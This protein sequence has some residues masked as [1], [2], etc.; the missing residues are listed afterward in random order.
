MALSEQQ[1]FPRQK[2]LYYL[3]GLT[4]AGFLLRINHTWSES[5]TAD[6]ASALLRLQFGTFGEMI[7]KGV[8]PD[9]HPAFTQTLLWFWIKLF[10]NSEFSI[11]LP[12][13]LMGT[14][15][16]WLSGCA[17]RRWFGVGTALAVAA[18]VAFLQL[19]VMYSQLA[20][21]YAAGLFFTML[22]ACAASRFS[23]Q[24]KIKWYH[25]AV[26]AV[27]A[28]GAAYS[29]YFSLLTTLLL[30]IGGVFLAS[31]IN[32]VSY[33]IACVLALLLFLP[34]V[35]ITNSQLE[36][37]GIGGPGG[38][39]APPTPDFF[40][41]HVLVIFDSSRGLTYL[42][43]GIAFICI[44]INNHRPTKQQII[45]LLIWLLPLLTGY[46]YSVYKN[47]VLQHSVLL[48]SFP[49]F[50][51]FLF[52]WFPNEGDVR[53]PWV[54]ANVLIIVFASYITW[55]KP[56]RLTDHFGRLKEL[57]T[58][59]AETQEQNQNVEAMYN[60][61]AP[62]FI[63]YYLQRHPQLAAQQVS[64]VTHSDE[65]DEMRQLRDRV[66][67]SSADY[68]VYGWSTR[69]S[70][71]AA[72]DIIAL[73]FPCLIEKHEWFNSAVYVFAR[74]NQTGE[75]CPFHS[76][77]LSY[78]FMNIRAG[79]TIRTMWSPAC[80][81]SGDAFTLDSSCQYGPLL[82]ARVG[83]VLSNPDNEIILHAS[84][85]PELAGTQAVLVVEYMRDG[86]LLLWTGMDT[87]TQLDS[88][89]TGWQTVYFGQRPP[90]RLLRSDSIRAYVYTPELKRIS[91]RNLAFMTRLGHRGIHG[92]RPD[93]E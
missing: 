2:F 57:V 68:F 25:I 35:G 67:H 84:L 92:P 65:H 51:M 86:Q 75:Q 36:I 47:P 64:F 78:S 90:I 89:Y 21:P 1:A 60:V 22:A 19:P 11:R 14:A 49:F 58:V 20:R 54:F 26:F 16:I 73:E 61:D 10:G 53:W 32:V 29:H 52:S 9:G 33:L 77:L 81:Q 71:P 43:L 45:V 4:L 42:M 66:L 82:R 7:E 28:A 70:S 38:W 37:G 30:G 85:F 6:E 3:A 23:Q 13:V 91:F 76:T 15:A 59:L 17:A 44:I 79:D 27:S 88:N 39:L 46:F 56:F 12:F 5:I 40:W 74:A 24:E 62:Y 63:Q 50:L 69:E 31:R 34:H 55:Y 8:R 87:R 72:L 80:G 18:G 48:F 41:S 83:D 93:F